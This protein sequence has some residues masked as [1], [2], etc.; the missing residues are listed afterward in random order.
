MRTTRHHPGNGFTLIE[1]LTVIT[2]I[3]ILASLLFPVFS[4]AREKARQASCQSNLKQIGLAITMYASDYDGI[5]PDPNPNFY[6]GEGCPG[7]SA[8]AD[9]SGTAGGCTGR[10]YSWQAVIST[11]VKNQQL[12]VCPSSTQL[13]PQG[14]NDNTCTGAWTSGCNGTGYAYNGAYWGSAPNASGTA[15][16][17]ICDP[18][19]STL[20]KKGVGGYRAL[21][22]DI[23]D[24]SGTLIVADSP[25]NGRYV[26]GDNDGG[27]AGGPAGDPFAQGSQY[28][29]QLR[30]NE[31]FN[32][33]WADG[34]VKWN[35]GRLKW[36]VWTSDED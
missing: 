24:P 12:L 31:G 5:L 15:A 10:E 9:E 21:D 32:V 1:L 2:I 3:A 23:A 26:M 18:L 30:H 11:Y 29:P 17:P 19:S 16:D 20:C 25:S 4:K 13:K 33:L 36:Q 6:L 34:H 7:G 22:G 35:K 14:A 27:A 8:G 28:Y